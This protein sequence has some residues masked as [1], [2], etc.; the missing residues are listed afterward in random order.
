MVDSMK[1]Q[2]PKMFSSCPHRAFLQ[3]ALAALESNQIASGLAAIFG[4]PQIEIP[5][6]CGSHIDHI[7]VFL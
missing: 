7:W 3:A 5:K 4:A 6:K 1:I 2:S